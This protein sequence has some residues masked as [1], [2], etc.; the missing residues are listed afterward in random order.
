MPN[1]RYDRAH[2]KVRKRWIPKVRA[3]KVLCAR[4]G[5]PIAPNELSDL[6]HDDADPG[7]RRYLG[8]SHRRCNRAVVTHLKQAMTAEPTR[9]SRKW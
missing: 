1:R 8:P 4:C 7:N 2:Q 5:D 6:D 3:G 9:H